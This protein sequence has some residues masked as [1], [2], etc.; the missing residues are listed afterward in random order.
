MWPIKTPVIVE[1]SQKV[2]LANRRISGD[3]LIN[4]RVG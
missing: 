3:V 1:L 4:A 2:T